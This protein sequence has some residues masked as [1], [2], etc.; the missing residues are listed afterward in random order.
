MLQTPALLT[1]VPPSQILMGNSKAS[2]LCG[3]QQRELVNTP[4]S[5]I[6]PGWIEDYR[7]RASEGSTGKWE[8]ETH[9][10]NQRTQ[11][12]EDVS[13]IITKLSSDEQWA[14]VEIQSAGAREEQQNEL[15][16]RM[17]FLEM[18]HLLAKS[19]QQS[20]LCAS[21]E[22][23][24]EAGSVLMSATHLAV[25]QA[26]GSHFTLKRCAAW[27]E[28]DK[29]PEQLHPGDLANLSQTSV[30]VVGKR[31][32]SYL[33]RIA[34][35]GGFAY[36]ASAPLGQP[37]ARIG[38]L[39]VAGI[40]PVPS[41][42]ALAFLP[43]LA[44]SITTILENQ[45]LTS[46]L[47]SHVHNQN[48]ELA[49]KSAVKDSVLDGVILI[50]PQLTI[51][52]LNPSAE[53]MLGYP[54]REL[55][56]QPYQDVLVT[57]DEFSF[58]F[59]VDSTDGKISDL[60]DIRIFRRDGRSFLA[61]VRILSV[62]DG[63][64]LINHVILIQDLTEEDQIRQHS[65]QLEQRA[66]LGDITAVFAH[67][68]RNPIN[69]ISTGLQLIALNLPEGDPNQ[70]I[71][72]RL[73][74]DCDR[75]NELMKSVL[76]YAKPQEYKMELV[77]LGQSLRQLLERWRSRLA[78]ANIK[79]QLQVEKD[80]PLI[81]G[82]VRALDQVW[83]NL[84]TNAMQA[85]EGE[86]G[87]LIIKVRKISTPDYSQRVEVS[88]SDTG[89]GIPEENREKIFEAFYT[90]NRS[91]TGLGLSITKHILTAHK[92]TIHVTSIPGGTAFQILLPF[93]KQP[94]EP[95]AEV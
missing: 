62:T 76:A 19:M 95:E 5:S 17:R 4:I 91:G 32:T 25:Y 48:I 3:M 77:D 21:L 8:F 38:I 20:D 83:G 80:I 43:I 24:L 36:L 69:N 27:G 6:F 93:P 11:V 55:R 12:R 94:I 29:F 33:H 1:D 23:A 56:G 92:G 22:M 15:N 79:Y 10:I 64:H 47:Q 52:E 67:E 50:T 39:A 86:G 35:T 40:N 54:S 45:V 51:Q 87:S 42:D 71:A 73:Q 41:D 74:Q 72:L 53:A 26:D 31:P 9:L 59:Q 37:N 2:R 75:V 34:R 58:P 61:H 60:G 63:D 88:I 66:S 30:W 90:T 28:G 82:D 57:T 13:L 46:N 84:I 70:E 68:V 49:I 65:Q 89:P 14:L 7:N 81:E 18:H 85:M 16:R 44:G 78:Q